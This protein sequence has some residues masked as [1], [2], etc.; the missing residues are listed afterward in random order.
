MIKKVFLCF[1]TSYDNFLVLRIRSQNV[2]AM[3]SIIYPTFMVESIL[4][5]I[6]NEKCCL[7]S[8]YDKS[9]MKFMK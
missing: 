9:N 6:D 7:S 3:R 8:S 5:T 4:I 1:R 2:L